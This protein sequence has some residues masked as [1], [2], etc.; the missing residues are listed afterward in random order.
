[1]LTALFNLVWNIQK[2]K[3]TILLEY[4]GKMFLSIEKVL[5]KLS[6]NQP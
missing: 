1:M 5:E 3:W 6:E 2:S 4:Q